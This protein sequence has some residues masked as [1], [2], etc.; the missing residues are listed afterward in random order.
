MERRISKTMT[1]FASAATLL[2][3]LGFGFALH[4]SVLGYQNQVHLLTA[5]IQET[6]ATGELELAT[7]RFYLR[8]LVIAL[9]ATV[10]LFLIFASLLVVLRKTFSVESGDLLEHLKRLQLE[11]GERDRE[12]KILAERE[13]A[14]SK[15]IARLRDEFI[16]V[17]A[18]ELRAPVAAIEGNIM[19]FMSEIDMKELS[20]DQRGILQDICTAA[21]RLSQLVIDLLNV[22]RIESGTIRIAFEQTPIAQIILRS[23]Q[24]IE[25]LAAQTG[26]RLVFDKEEIAALPSIMGDAQRLQEVF[27]NIL[28]NAIKYN[29]AG[30]IVAVSARQATDNHLTISV[31]DTGIGMNESELTHLFSKFWRANPS[32]EGTGLGLWITKQI[33]EKMHGSIFVEST[34][35]KGSS[36]HISLK[37]LSSP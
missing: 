31:S 18:H 16:F 5:Q 8:I 12:L 35:G 13:I 4:S 27:S 10:V 1:V 21:S 37:V 24:E 6:A 15:E 23:L 33:V 7:T 25:G 19:L 36:F 26:V 30:G 3:S 28:L 11:V 14:K 20:E 34:K 17:A 32:I 29:V 2:L 22:S 9:I